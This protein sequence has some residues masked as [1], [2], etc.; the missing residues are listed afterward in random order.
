MQIHALILCRLTHYKRNVPSS[1]RIVLIPGGGKSEYLKEFE[2]RY[3][4][5]KELSLKIVAGTD[6]AGKDIISDG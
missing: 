6:D 5:N 1:E 2:V 3:L 4:D